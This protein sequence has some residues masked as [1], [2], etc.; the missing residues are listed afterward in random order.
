MRIVAQEHIIPIPLF[1]YLLYTSRRS[2]NTNY[3]VF[4]FNRPKLTV[5]KELRSE[6]IVYVHFIYIWV[7][8]EDNYSNI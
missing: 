6:M 7:I 4:G 1:L 5:V 8:D 3:T 2:S